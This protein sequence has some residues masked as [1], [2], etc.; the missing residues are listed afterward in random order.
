MLRPSY[1]LNRQASFSTLVLCLLVALLANCQT[2][3][4]PKPSQLSQAQVRPSELPDTLAS[5]NSRLPE[6]LPSVKP[7]A[8][9]SNQI[10]AVATASASAVAQPSSL[11]PSPVSETKK[12]YRP[13]VN[14]R[15]QWQLTGTLNTSYPVDAYDIDLFDTTP[16]SIQALKQQGKKVIC[17][18]S[19]GS[20]EDWRPDYD[21]FQAE[22]QGKNLDDWPGEK[23]LLFDLVY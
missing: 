17:Y 12:W 7:L 1:K 2:S 3:L 4:N 14:L 9:A 15:W 6:S 8:S 23:W 21:Q 10:V 16:E 18:F 13:A 11:A 19:A 5:A 22:D 20:S